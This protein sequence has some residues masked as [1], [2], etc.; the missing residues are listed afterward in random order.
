VEWERGDLKQA[1][2]HLQAS[3]QTACEIG[4]RYELGVPLVALAELCA[5]DPGA[6]PGR[7]AE[8]AAEAA[9]LFE[10]MGASYELSRALAARDGRSPKR[11]SRAGPAPSKGQ[12][13]D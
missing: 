9:A 12:R 5:Q 1:E 13:L 10:E 6:A 4:A 11:S 2:D 3:I 7:A 8:L